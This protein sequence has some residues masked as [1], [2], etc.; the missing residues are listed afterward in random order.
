MLG[1]IAGDIIGSPFEV[2]NV[3]TRDFPLFSSASRF[4]D[5]T[6]LTLAV[7][8]ALLLGVDY[9]STYRRFALAY[10]YAGYGGMFVQWASDPETGPY[11]SYGNGAAMRVSPIG[12]A[13][14]TEEDVLDAA[15]E[16]ADPTHN[17][18]ESY[19]GA[20]AIA[21]AVFLARKG[22]SKAD[23]LARVEA[24]SGYDLNFTLDEIRDS[25][26]FDVSC[27]GSVPQALV[28]F[29]EGT[30]FEDAIRG[31]ISIGGDSD[32]IACMTGAIAE[33]HF[34]GVPPAIEREV[35]ARLDA[36]LLSLLDTFREA[37]P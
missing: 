27:Q 18:P 16:S 36:P 19:R 14:E 33:A 10:P 9:A 3:K 8:E 26:S 2:E 12:H 11:E 21:L 34:G 22:H 6:V 28:A 23:I 5:D 25:Y 31:A 15:L 13:F 37:F 1:A 20:Q 7:A 35:R 32:T 4:T 29:R 17:H 30:D 24:H